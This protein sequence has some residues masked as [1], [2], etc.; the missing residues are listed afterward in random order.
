MILGHLEGDALKT[1]QNNLL[2][3]N[4]KVSLLTGEDRRKHYTT[5][6]AD[7]DKRTDNNLND[8]LEKFSDELQNEYYYMIP[9]NEYYY[10]IPLRFL[11]NLN[12]V[13]Q[14]VKFKTKWLIT[15]EQ[16]YQKRFETKANQPNDALPTSVDAEIILT[17]TPYLLF[18][19][20][21]LDDYY[22]AYLEGN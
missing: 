15:F 8:R 9:L 17:A 19:Q 16:G 2:Y 7:A 13:N 10:M 4:K 21:Q 5:Q 6:T 11:F 12:L 20:F 1:F 18:K 14:P 22:G 3:S